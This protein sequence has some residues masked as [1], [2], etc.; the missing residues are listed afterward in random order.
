[1]SILDWLTA[2]GANNQ[3]GPL[4]EKYPT[5]QPGSGITD[6]GSA[7][8]Q[9]A[10]GE[11]ANRIQKGNWTQDYD[12]LMMQAEQLRNQNE[13]DA[14]KKMAQTSYILGG[15]N[16]YKPATLNFGGTQMALP[17]FGFGPK[18]PSAAQMQ[19]ASTLQG[20]LLSRLAPGGSYLP[21]SL[22]SYANPGTLENITR[23][24]GAGAGILGA[25]GNI[26]KNTSAAKKAGG[27]VSNLLTGGGGQNL[28]FD[29]AGGMTP[30]ALPSSAA[31]DA[32]AAGV[33]PSAIDNGL[34]ASGLLSSS[35]LPSSTIEGLMSATPDDMSS[36]ANNVGGGDGG[37]GGNLLSKIPG[38]GSGVGATISKYLPYV[39]AVTGGL[40][41]LH[42]DGLGGDIMHGAETGASIGSIVPGL[43]TLIGGG[44]GAGVGALRRLFSGIG[45]PS[46]TELAGRQTQSTGTNQYTQGA[47]D[48]ERQEAQN[49]G[50]GNA[51]DALGLIMTRDA[52]MKNGLAGDQAEKQAESLW[53]NFMNSTKQGS[54][55]EQTALNNL[56]SATGRQN[57]YATPIIGTPS[58]YKDPFS[59]F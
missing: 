27:A 1:M 18:A 23:F 56:Y 44:I 24:G 34:T 33:A 58:T 50:W 8:E 6:L 19:G 31:L 7:I 11:R 25:I 49:A 52:L 36:I 38:L 32:A 57:P 26:L 48:A 3:P 40:G 51:N 5:S 2:L 17:D 39:G 47:T 29:T 30:A 21:T 43:G 53:G 35:S 45:G 20:Q 9:I 37:L 22:D 46:Q 4:S 10:N 12:K 28:G 16:P 13:S 41:L 54:G 42:E 55:A 59:G 15:G 14:M